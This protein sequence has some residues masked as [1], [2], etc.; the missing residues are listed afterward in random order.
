MNDFVDAKYCLRLFDFF[1]LPY[2]WFEN[3]SEN[4][5]S[6]LV[7][8]NRGRQSELSKTGV[9][10]CRQRDCFDRNVPTDVRK[11]AVFCSYQREH[12]KI[13]RKLVINRSNGFNDLE[14]PGVGI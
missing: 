9:C 7:L 6:H 2:F 4:C 5:K 1:V 11:G 14:I 12:Q 3:R 8:I 13:F 10:T